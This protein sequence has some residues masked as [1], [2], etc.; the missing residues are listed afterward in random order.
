MSVQTNIDSAMA[1]AAAPARDISLRLKA[2]KLRPADLSVNVRLKPDLT[3]NYMCAML[4]TRAGQHIAYAAGWERNRIAKPK[5]GP[6]SLWLDSAAFDVT[7]KEVDQLI[8]AFG[9]YGLRVE[10]EP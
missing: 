7:A 4:W 8:Q 1:P 9:K 6:A 10:S 2:N 3:I 5:D